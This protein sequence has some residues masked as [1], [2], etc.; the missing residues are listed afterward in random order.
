MSKRQRQRRP[1]LFE[2]EL[3]AGA[4]LP[5]NAAYRLPM[6]NTTRDQQLL[7]AVWKLEAQGKGPTH[8]YRLLGWRPKEVVSPSG[9]VVRSTV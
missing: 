7:L 6:G 4:A 1:R 8:Y 5:P 9:L 2:N 3:P